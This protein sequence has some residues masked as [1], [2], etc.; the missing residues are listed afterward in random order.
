MAVDYSEK[1]VG[2]ASAVL[3]TSE[4]AGAALSLDQ[5]RDKRVSVDLSFTIGSLTNVVVVFYVSDDGTTY[6]QL[7][8]GATAL[9]ETLTA[10]GERAYQMPSLAG[11]KYFRVSVNGTGTVTSSLCDFTYRFDKRYPY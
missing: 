8:D 5:V 2:R 4:V 7:Y 3:T 1:L 11:W 10:D 6:D 9:T